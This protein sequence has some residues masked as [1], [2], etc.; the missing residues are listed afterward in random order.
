MLIFDISILVKEEWFLEVIVVGRMWFVGGGN[1]CIRLFI[2]FC[3]CYSFFV[4]ELVFFKIELVEKG[5]ILW[6]RRR[7]IMNKW[8]LVFWKVKV[9]FNMF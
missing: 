3:F 9:V 5:F 7:R 6:R 8:I 2:F 4:L 1:F